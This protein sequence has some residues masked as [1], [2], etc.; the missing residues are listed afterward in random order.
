[1]LCLVMTTT[2][3]AESISESQA[4]S[5]AT[6]FMINHGLRTS[7]LN[8][9]HKAQRLGSAQKTAFYVFNNDFKDSGFIIVAGDD[10]VPAVLGYSDNG[11][12]DANDVPQAMQELLDSYMAQI[13]E[14][15]NGGTAITLS[16]DKGPISPLV[17]A[18]WSQNSPYNIL[19]P[20]LPNGNHAYAGCVATALAQV[21]HYWQW[22]ARPTTAIPAY[23]SSTLS[24]V[25]PE[26]PVVDFDWE[27]MQNTYQT[28]DTTS[29]SGMAA[30]TLTLYCAQAL[31][32]DFK[33]TGSGAT[34][35]KIPMYLSYYFGY[36][37]AHTLR[38]TSYTTQGWAD[39]IYSELADSRPVIFSG[40]KATGGHAFVCDGYDGNG[41]FHINWGWNGRSNGYFLLNVLNP[42]LQG[43]GSASGA[44]GYIYDQAAVVGIEP[45]TETNN[46]VM[47]TVT[48]MKLNS[49]TATRYSSSSDFT[50]TISARFYNYTAHIFAADFGWGLY[51]GETFVKKLYSVY[52]SSSTPGKY[53]TLNEREVDFGSGISNGTYRILPICSERSANNWKPCNGADKNYIEVTISGN[54]CTFKGYG[55]AGTPNYM[56]N[57]ITCSGNMHP[58]RPVDINVNLTNNGYSDNLLLYMFVNGTFTAT[59]YVGLETG[60]TGDIPYRYMPTATGTYTL[61]F[62]LNE[63][64]SNP[65]ASRTLTINEMPAANLSASIEILNVTDATNRIITSDKFSVVLTI[66]NN[67][68]TTYSEDI[69][70]K[71]FKNI[72]GT[73]GSNV[74][75]KSQ[76]ITLAP[77]ATTTVQFDMDNVT[78]GWRYF[79]KTYYYSSGSEK[80]LITASTHTIIFPEAPEFIVGDVNGDGAVS[81][82]DVTA[83]IDYL[84]SG[85]ASMINL[86]TADCNQDGGVSITDVTALIDFLLRSS[87]Y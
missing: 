36:N 7:G 15:D 54:T 70:A 83:L 35:A 37:N 9:A 84:L 77:G 11:S 32:M 27:S 33:T 69:S 20:F 18:A 80:D 57:D 68:T 19:L 73:S 16:T 59:G 5:I 13:E 45:T 81:I 62:S 82:I 38:R 63:D 64:G 12:F 24:F 39:A 28:T 78:D 87:W 74:Q 43:T 67:G 52:T 60:E 58:N 42:D 46:E 86:D 85:D 48:D 40:S 8:I 21:M 55:T 79:V 56:V 1:M 29:A 30:A 72:Q 76:F 47:F 4:K 26:L 14:M 51:Q 53:F 17:K 75:G 44:Y 61:T 10:R 6:N 41:M 49:Y 2:A 65:I 23:T 66:T 3:W 22:P 31:E 50:A 34:T 25:M 71:M